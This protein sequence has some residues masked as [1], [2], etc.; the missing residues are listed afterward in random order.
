MEVRQYTGK[1]K[2]IFSSSTDSGRPI[3]DVT[4][5]AVLRR[6]GFDLKD[7]ITSHGFRAMAR[8]I[9]HEKLGYQPDVVEV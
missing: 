9:L 3:S 1:K 7:E 5:N 2:Y 8:T 4:L 6:I